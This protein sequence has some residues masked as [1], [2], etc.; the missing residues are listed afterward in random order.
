MRNSGIMDTHGFACIQT[1]QSYAPAWLKIEFVSES[2]FC[3]S[4]KEM[5]L[6]V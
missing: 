5:I 4:N 1:N 3:E 6:E 2:L